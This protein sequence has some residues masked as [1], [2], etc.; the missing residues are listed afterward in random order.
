[1][2]ATPNNL[3]YR[4]GYVYD[5]GLMADEAVP[6]NTFR[7]LGICIFLEQLKTLFS[8]CVSILLSSFSLSLSLNVGRL[9]DIVFPMTSANK[10]E[11]IRLHHFTCSAGI[12]LKNRVI[13]HQRF[14][15]QTNSRR[16]FLLIIKVE[17]RQKK[18]C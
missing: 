9:G 2:C 7:Y 5:V 13:T 17:T 3:A 8:T 16:L 4:Y 6:H 11:L 1:M 18:I 14:K 12:L 10:I 15:S